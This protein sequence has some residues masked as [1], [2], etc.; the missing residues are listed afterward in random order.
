MYEPAK[1]EHLA[2]VLEIIHADEIM[3]FSS[4]YPHWDTD[5]PVRATAAV[6]A[7]LR[8]AIMRGNPASLYGLGAR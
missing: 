1:R 4:D 7:H 3:L 8:D 6:P 5:D 2:Q